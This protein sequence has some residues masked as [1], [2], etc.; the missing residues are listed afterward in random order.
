M[1]ILNQRKGC[2][3]RAFSSIAKDRYQSPAKRKGTPDEQQITVAA[4]EKNQNQAGDD[5][6]RL[7]GTR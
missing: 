1:L 4:N 3:Y 6:Y 7:W 5:K 2:F